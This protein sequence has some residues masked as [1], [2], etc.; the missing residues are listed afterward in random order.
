MPLRMLNASRPAAVDN[1][2]RSFLALREQ[3]GSLP[4]A[5]KR[6]PDTPIGPRLQLPTTI[7]LTLTERKII[8]AIARLRYNHDRQVGITDQRVQEDTHGWLRDLYGF[9]SEYVF[10]KVANVMVDLTTEPRSG[11]VDAKLASGIT[12]DVKG[13]PHESG[14]LICPMKDTQKLHADIFV[15]VT[16]DL[17]VT[18]EGRQRLDEPA[19]GTVQG[20]AWKEDLLDRRAIVGLK[21]R[22]NGDVVDTYVINRTSMFRTL[23]LV[24][25]PLR[26]DYPCVHN[27][28]VDPGVAN[29]LAGL[30]D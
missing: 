16:V 12:V 6:R 3:V 26:A 17:P 8:E 1:L 20:W 18:R 22:D 14:R 19:S 29:A 7:S 23:P 2:G 30:L 27:P 21:K 28:V 4:P 13:T 5:K 10:S 25:R 9:A 11:G 24:T 15:L